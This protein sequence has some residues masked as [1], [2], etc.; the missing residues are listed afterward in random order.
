MSGIDTIRGQRLA[1]PAP[2]KQ[3]LLSLFQL[4]VDIRAAA[5]RLKRKR[6]GSR[7]G[8]IGRR[9]LSDRRCFD[10][11]IQEFSLDRLGHAET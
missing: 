9:S 5:L 1:M 4:H 3:K 7:A 11:V 8:R 6:I 2:V 10:V